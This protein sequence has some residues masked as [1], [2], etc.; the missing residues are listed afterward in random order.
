MVRRSAARNLAYLRNNV[1]AELGVDLTRVL[2]LSDPTSV[3]LTQDN[4]IGPDHR[5]CQTLAAGCQGLMVPSAARLGL[6]LVILPQNLPEPLPIRVV[7]STELPLD[8]IARERGGETP[9]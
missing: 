2:D 4:L 8:T 7:H 3:G 1:L 5:A 6:N 9:T